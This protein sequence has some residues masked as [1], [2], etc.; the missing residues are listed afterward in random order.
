MNL[1]VQIL[2]FKVMTSF[3]SIFEN[4][5]I[6]L[7]TGPLLERLKREFLIDVDHEELSNML[8]NEVMTLKIRICI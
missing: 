8:T 4:S 2:I 1:Y 5:P 7:T 6:V 3:V